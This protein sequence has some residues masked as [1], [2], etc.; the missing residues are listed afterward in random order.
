VTTKLQS[1]LGQFDLIVGTEEEFHIAGGAT[2]TLVALLN[3]RRV[4]DAILVC[5]RGA[6]GAV[7]IDGAIPDDLNQARSAPGFPVEVFNVLG[8]GDG[9]FAGLLKGWLADESWEESLSYANACGALAVSRHGCTPAYPTAVELDFFMRRGVVRPDVRNDQDM[10]QLHW[11]QTRPGVFPD[12]RVFA[13]DHRS[14]LEELP[15]YSQENGAAFK[16][17]CLKATLAVQRGRPGYGMLCDD[18]VGR[19]ALH[20]AADTDLWFARPCELPGSRPLKLEPELGP[21][22]GGLQEWARRTVVK[23]LCFC[24]PEDQSDMQASQEETIERVYTAARRNGLEFLLEIVASSVAPVDDNSVANQIRRFY[25]RGIYP[26][27]WKLEPSASTSAWQNICNTIEQN[28]PYCR[29]I[30]VL[31]L[32]AS[33]SDLA[34]SFDV[35]ARFDLVK[36]FAVGRSILGEAAAAWMLDEL[37]DDEAIAAMTKRFETLCAIWDRSRSS[38]AAGTTPVTRPA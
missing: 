13:F 17:L 16:D 35:A 14:Q 22:C 1:T 21:D 27:W 19:R 9:F 15:G 25:D 26:D 10:E 34:A 24:H 32:N 30:V 3:V 38:N 20:A 28:D 18:R 7:V 33:D 23:V 37:T 4:T 31:G 11:S 12:L 5:K 29:G 8:A 2:N 6:A 36:G